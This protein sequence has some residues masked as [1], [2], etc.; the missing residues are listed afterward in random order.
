MAYRL[1]LRTRRLLG[2]QRCGT[3]GDSPIRVGR[4]IGHVYVINLDRQPE[5]WRR[6]VD[7]LDNVLDSSGVPL[8]HRTTRVSAVDACEDHDYPRQGLVEST[9]TLGDQLF[10]DPHPLASADRLD[11]DERIDMSP[12]EIAVA[13][14]H[15][16]V[17]RRIASGPHS[18]AMVLEDDVW[19]HPRFARVVD[20]AWS[21]L[22]AD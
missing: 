22:R 14:S 7:E 2:R 21:E 6:M 18:Y 13:C 15:I 16:D 4:P 1:A 10:V 17:W 19:F 5:R 8:S 12:Q 3:F 11:L 20:Q 9:Y